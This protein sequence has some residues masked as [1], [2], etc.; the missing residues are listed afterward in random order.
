MTN[1]SSFLVCIAGG[2]DFNRRMSARLRN[3]T[4][5]DFNLSVITTNL[6]EVKTT[7][8]S[9]RPQVIILDINPQTNR[10]DLAWLRA[11]LTHLRDRLKDSTYIILSCTSP[12][13]FVLAGDL[14]FA[15]DGTSKPSGLLD[16]FLLSPP[17]G[18]PTI[19]SLE[20]QLI[21]AIRY[22]QALWVE[23]Q[24]R[25]SLP[26]MNDDDWVP[27]ICDP[28][29]RSVWLRW[30]PRY[31]RYVNE[32][33]IVVGPTGSGKTRLAKALHT[34][35]GRTGPFVSITPRDF[36]STE[37]VQTE[38][39]GAVPG[40]YTGAVEKW[41]LVKKAE[42]GTLFIDELQS[43]DLDLQG[44]LI[45]FI[46]SKSYRRVG[47]A[48]SHTADVR[49]VFATNRP[50]G[51]LVGDGSLRDDFAYRL[52]RLQIEVLPLSERRLD[53]AAGV[54]FALAKILRERSE[55]GPTTHQIEGI[56]RHAYQALLSAPWPG[57]LRQVENTVAKLIEVADIRGL[58]FIDQAC[59]DEALQASLG[60]KPP[61]AEQ[62]FQAALR[63]ASER[64]K[65][66]H[67]SSLDSFLTALSTTCRERALE[68]SGGNP[69]GAAALLNE[70]PHALSLF[71]A[72]H[73]NLSSGDLQS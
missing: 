28:K 2:T 11:A 6:S 64:A 43:I 40:A 53:I 9:E 59:A 48:A 37:L 21:D 46:E 20:D 4:G 8:L 34:L 60:Y 10:R 22:A 32:N 27:S 47:E 14:L 71:Q 18:I 56:D 7:A 13:R 58:R 36:S 52:E 42:Q 67:F 33:P 73:K 44:K 66:E 39:F 16:T 35:S 65:S 25:F 57:N 29:S 62:I 38:L 61:T 63:I 26:Q 23:G 19:A 45:T 69:D 55:Q 12:E 68:V 5:D 50:L 72:A 49:F 15:D 54:C 1:H 24:Q 30:L 70:S 3:E 31:A 41:G 17:P 51:E